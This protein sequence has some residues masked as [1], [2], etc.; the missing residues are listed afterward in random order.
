ME[1]GEAEEMS[2]QYI[3]ASSSQIVIISMF[4]GSTT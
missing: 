1:D 4:C 2:E 3:R